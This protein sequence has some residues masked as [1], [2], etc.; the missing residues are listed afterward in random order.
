MPV[1]VDPS[2]GTGYWQYV[3]PMAYAGIAAGADGLMIEVHPD[4]AHALSDGGQSLKPSRFEELM[5][6]LRSSPRPRVERCESAQKRRS[7]R[8][9]SSPA[10]PA[11][12]PPGDTIAVIAPASAAKQSR[13]LRRGADG[14]TRSASDLRVLPQAFARRRPLRRHGR[15]PRRRATQA[16]ADPR[17]AAY[18]SHARRVRRGTSA[19]ACRPRSRRAPAEDTGRL[20]RCNVASHVR[21]RQARLGDVSR[22]DGRY[23]L[24][25]ARRRRPCLVARYV[26]R[27]SPATHLRLGV[28]LRRGVAKGK[29]FGG[30]LSILVSLLGTPYAVDLSNRILFLEDVNEEPYSLDRMLTQLRQTGQFARHAGSSSARCRTADGGAS[31]WRAARANRRPRHT[32]RVRSTER[33]RP[34]QAHRSTR[35]T[36]SSR[37]GRRTLEILESGV[38]SGRR[39][40]G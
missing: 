3:T 1:I 37:P 34:R 26:A 8:L 29:L 14:S 5:R 39:S 23:G 22:A 24:S 12:A 33:P 2:H 27:R 13:I 7:S 17:C 6:G 25:E 20:Q 21:D 40:S 38:S 28:T 31:C 35:R 32:R 9:A 11:C 36:R 15:S 10:P 16:L 18:L 30:C 19:A 4:P